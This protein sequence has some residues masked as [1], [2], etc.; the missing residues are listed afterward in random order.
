MSTR[1]PLRLMSAFGSVTLAATTGLVMLQL[2]ATASAA[3]LSAA[4]KPPSFVL[5]NLSDGGGFNPLARG[6][7][8]ATIADF[9]GDGDID[10]LVPNLNRLGIVVLLGNGHGDLGD[11]V[12]TTLPAAAG[13]VDADTADF[14]GDGK[15]DAAAATYGD[16][17]AAVQ[18]LLG[19]GNGS[20]T[21]SQRMPYGDSATV[22]AITVAD[23]TGDGKPDVAAT[24]NAPLGPTIEVF[25]GK[26]DGS[27][28]TATSY[29]SDIQLTYDG[30]DSADV[31]DDGDPDLVYLAGCPTVQLN[32]GHGV[33]GDHICTR[34]G[35]LGGVTFT[36]GDFDGDGVLDL[37]TGDASGGN[38]TIGLGTGKG[39][40]VAK[41]N[42]NKIGKQVNSIT[43]GDFTGD[44]VLDVLASADA[45]PS[46]PTRVAIVLR[47]KGDG[48][49]AEQAS[50]ATGG[51]GLAGADLNGD[52][53]LDLISAGF[54]RKDVS[55]TLNLGNGRFHAP[56]VYAGATQ[57]IAYLTRS[58][59]VDNDGQADVVAATT[60]GLL[61][62][63]L[64]G[65]R[66]ALELPP[67]KS[68][69]GPIKSLA[70]SDVNGD[71]NVDVVG[72]SFPDDN[73]FV[74][75]GTGDGHFEAPTYYNNGSG[76]AVLGVAVGDV[77]G[78]GKPDIVSNTFAA[79]SVLPNTGDGTFAAPIVSGAGAGFQVSTMLADVNADG[80]LDAV[81]VIRTGTPD[82][83]S[84]QVI[85]NLGKGDGTFTAG[86]QVTVDTNVYAAAA[87]DIKAGQSPSVVLVGLQGYH[88]GRTGLYLLRNVG[89]Q[90]TAGAYLGGPGSDLT[91]ADFNRDG[92]LDV[93]TIGPGELALFANAG[94]GTLVSAGTLGASNGAAGVSA[95]NVTGG[96]GVDLVELDST[97]PVQ[98]EIYENNTK[99]R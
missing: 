41:A 61:N 55:A 76:A 12:I 56:R 98:L 1:A 39:K 18:I 49:F 42:Y 83:A 93:A 32:D 90:L 51:D 46:A 50:Y 63:F 64:H 67:I 11:P 87:I 81:A 65:K 23:F 24:K 37:A 2:P 25:V 69:G 84:S 52:G 3:D 68:A 40:F 43:T 57:G 66:G 72:G 4:P 85:T 45:Y 17:G 28:G 82:N 26:G 60:S 88:S 80:K 15:A 54:D 16:N 78:D 22:D 34:S 74:M 29:P 14:N 8:S 97:N 58:A 75:D 53:L 5:P 92:R 77:T 99:R 19:K 38:V 94:D 33:F 89:G 79:I 44:G 36:L 13:A 35:R 95:G 73:I 6:G 30:L 9:N 7:V 21:V 59:D 91:V 62:V 71:G 10:T 48:T 47:G 20:F 27:F 70:L 31:D 86:P 96:K